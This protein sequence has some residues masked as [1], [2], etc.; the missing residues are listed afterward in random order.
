[1]IFDPVPG[2][3][4]AKDSMSLPTLKSSN[5]YFLYLLS[6]LKSRSIFSSVKTMSVAII[7]GKSNAYSRVLYAAYHTQTHAVR[8]GTD[9]QLYGVHRGVFSI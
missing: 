4:W 6:Y 7:R 1:M 3:D 8:A 5:I 9:L 2:E